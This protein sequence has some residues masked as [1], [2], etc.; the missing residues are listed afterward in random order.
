MKLSRLKPLPQ[1]PGKR[2]AK[3]LPQMLGKRG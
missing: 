3:P 1:V 2:G